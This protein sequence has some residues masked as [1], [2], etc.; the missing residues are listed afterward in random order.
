[1]TEAL[2]SQPITPLRLF[3]DRVRAGAY[4]TRAFINAGMFAFFFYISQ[5]LEGA[6]NYSPL[7]VGYA[8]LPLTLVMF[9][10]AQLIHRFPARIRPATFVAGGVTV[11][12]V[13]MVWLS[14]LSAS[15]QFFP[16]I[17]LPMMMLGFGIG[18]AFIKLTGISVSGVPRSDEGAASGLVNVSQQVGASLGLAVM[19]TVFGAATTRAAADVPAGTPAGHRAQLILGHGTSAVLTGSAISLGIALLVVLLMVRTRSARQA[20]EPTSELPDGDLGMLTPAALPSA[21]PS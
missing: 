10:T 17:V 1:V 15:T 20:P 4:L 13:G 14:R 21:P 6:R 19:V 5:Y 3:A 18:I 16:N 8:F 12:F 2:T 11:G 7:G 9:T